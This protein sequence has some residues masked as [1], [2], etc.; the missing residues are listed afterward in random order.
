MYMSVACP[1]SDIH[2]TYPY[3]TYMDIHIDS[4]VRDTDPTVTEKPSKPT[5]LRV[6]DIWK[7]YMTVVWE[8]PKSD[9]GSAI[10]GYTLEQRDAF[11]VNYKFVA[12]L[13]AKTTQYQVCLPVNI[14]VQVQ[15]P[16]HTWVM[17]IIIITDFR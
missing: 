6:K 15:V 10:T 1:K 8:A 12:S 16:C 17:T 11:D 9:G 13:D 2:I 14:A 4:H 3:I 7:D 5:N